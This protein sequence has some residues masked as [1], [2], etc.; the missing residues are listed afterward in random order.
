MLLHTQDAGP[1]CAYSVMES[2]PEMYLTLNPV[3]YHGT[4]PCSQANKWMPLTYS[5]SMEVRIIIHPNRHI[6]ALLSQSHILPT[7]SILLRREGGY[8]LL[9]QAVELTLTL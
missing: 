5:E 1:L 4:T 7:F 9:F 6:I 8:L 2:E 3:L